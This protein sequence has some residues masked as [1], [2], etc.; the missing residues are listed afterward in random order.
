MF[1]LSESEFS[2]FIKALQ[3]AAE[4]H[5]AQKR[6]DG[7][8]PYINHPIEVT[9]I[10]WETG[11]VRD[12][13][14]LLAALLHDTVEDTN[15]SPAELREHFGED[16]MGLVLEMSDDKSLPKP[17]RKRLQVEHAPHKS[18]RARQIKLADKITNIQNLI[19]YPP[20]DWSLERKREYLD[21][22]KRV[23]DGLR[24]HNPD[25]EAA[26]DQALAEARAALA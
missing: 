21:W 6:K 25:L 24:G 1:T 15:T 13:S 22:S 10:L 3:F 4:K 12:I 11:G 20:T 26:Y 2:Q 9:R 14:T 16:V 5:K 7:V 23:I 18:P 17:E 19:R 8:I